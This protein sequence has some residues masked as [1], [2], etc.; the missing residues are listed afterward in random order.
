MEVK[1]LTAEQLQ[2]I[3]EEFEKIPQILDLRWKYNNLM[4][5]FRLTDAQH[6]GREIQRLHQVVLEEVVKEYNE[7]GKKLQLQDCG[8]P[9]KDLEMV[10]ALCV[11]LYLLIDVFDSAVRDVDETLRKTDEGYSLDIFGDLKPML[12]AFKTKLTTLDKDTTYMKDF[13]WSDAADNLYELALNKAKAVIR[14]KGQPNW[15][16][17]VKAWEKKSKLLDAEY[18]RNHPDG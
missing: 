1:D 10:N 4:K 5:A 15:G 9:P 11:M 17:N 8:L 16:E 7:S 13:A 3:D 6:I 12:D 18:K 2:Q 14:R